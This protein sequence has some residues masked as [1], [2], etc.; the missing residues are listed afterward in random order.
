MDTENNFKQ[1]SMISFKLILSFGDDMLITLSKVLS[2]LKD[3]YNSRNFKDFKGTV[4]KTKEQFILSAKKD[5][6]Y[7]NLQQHVVK[8]NMNELKTLKKMCKNRGIDI[9]IEKCPNNIDSIVERFEN[10]KELT[11]KE[12]DLLKAFTDINEDG[13]INN[14]FKDAA[15]V[16]F[17]GKD[18]ELVVDAVKDTEQKVTDISKRKIKAKN[19]R[20]E[21]VEQMEIDKL[22]NALNRKFGK[23][24]EKL[25]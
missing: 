5:R 7:S 8:N 19:K 16:W 25:R 22:L 21:L 2:S 9:F 14:I 20:K 4:Y 6:D 11:V 13:V 15:V 10:K 3:N 17:K 23:E 12:Q 1:V 24:H 18:I